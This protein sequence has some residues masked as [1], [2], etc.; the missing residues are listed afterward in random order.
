MLNFESHQNRTVHQFQTIKNTKQYS[1]ITKD[2]KHSENFR[3]IGNIR[4]II[5]PRSLS[6]GF[7]STNI[8]SA[9]ATTKDELLNDSTICISSTCCVQRNQRHPILP[10]RQ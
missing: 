10:R 2:E 7:H 9:I 4:R 1:V 8:A 3:K 5:L 6:N